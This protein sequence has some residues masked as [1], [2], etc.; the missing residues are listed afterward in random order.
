V[1]ALPPVVGV[2]LAGGRGSRMDGRDKGW[3]ELQGRPLIQWVL[4]RF[5]PQVDRVIISANRNL[6]RYAALGVEVVAD[7]LP[8]HQGPLAGLHA[9][10]AATRADLLASVPCDTPYLPLDLV[11]R[12][13]A[14]LRTSG[15]D[16][17]VPR[18]QG[19]VHPVFCLCRGEVQA[20]LERTLARGER[21]VE[22]W[23]RGLHAVEVGFEDAAAF[24]NINTPQDL[25]SSS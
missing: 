2:I 17:A 13:H 18:V 1:T 20:S 23:C 8:E 4:E 16:I 12:L 7:I 10:F 25:S 24:R 19:R 9:A 14:A 3:V 5:A 6:E 15:A 11:T 22:V 21:K